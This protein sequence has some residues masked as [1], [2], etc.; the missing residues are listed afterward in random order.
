M[1]SEVPI[2]EIKQAAKYTQHIRNKLY[3]RI[4]V[5]RAFS[6]VYG[7]LAPRP[8]RSFSPRNDAG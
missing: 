7:N 8:K 6:H 5:F 2:S 4:M 3:S 1:L